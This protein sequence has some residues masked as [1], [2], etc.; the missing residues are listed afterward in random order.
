MATLDGENLCSFR[1][2]TRSQIVDVEGNEIPCD[3]FSRLNVLFQA[4]AQIIIE[5]A[6]IGVN[7]RWGKLQV[8]LPLE[9]MA[10]QFMLCY[11]WVLFPADLGHGAPPRKKTTTPISTSSTQGAQVKMTILNQIPN[12]I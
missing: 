1:I 11:Q 5:A 7:R 3:N 9:P 10:G 8:R 2:G 4:K 12:D 6:S